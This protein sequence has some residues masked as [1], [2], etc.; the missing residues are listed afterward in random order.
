MSALIL[1]LLVQLVIQPSSHLAIQPDVPGRRYWPVSIEQMATTKR[2]HVQTCGV[3]TYARR[4]ADGDVHVT[5]S[6]GEDFVVLEIIPGLPLPTP[7][8]GQRIRAWGIHRIDRWH[9]T[10]RYPEGWPELHPLEWFTV[11]QRCPKDLL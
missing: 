3:V 6:S 8:K 5:L 7:K 2:T 4:L 11:V 10:D 1:A 9:K